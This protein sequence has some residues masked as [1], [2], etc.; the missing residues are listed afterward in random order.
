MRIFWALRPAI[1]GLSIGTGFGQV[2][3]HHNYVVGGLLLAAGAAVLLWHFLG[4][5][6]WKRRV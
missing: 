6:L 1:G 4:L 5:W 2:I 3:A